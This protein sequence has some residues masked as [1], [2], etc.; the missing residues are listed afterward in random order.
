MTLELYKE[1]RTYIKELIQGSEFENKIYCVGGCCR[2]EILDND[3]KDIDLVIELPDGGINFANWLYNNHYTKGHV[4]LYPRFGTA[5]FKFRKYPDIEIE[6][7]HTRCEKYAN[8]ISRNPET[9]YG[10]ILEDC[11]RR[12]LTINALYYNIS[13][14][15]FEDFCHL[16][17]HDIKNHIIRTPSDPNITYIDD[18]LRILRCVRFSCRY[19]WNIDPETYQALKDNIDRLSIL[20]QERIT[21]E[22]CKIL[23]SPNYIYGLNILEDIGALKYILTPY[24]IQFHAKNNL[25]KHNFYKYQPNLLISSLLDNLYVKMV[26][27]LYP[28]PQY[29]DQIMRIRKF[30]LA[31]NK[32]IFTLINLCQKYIEIFDNEVNDKNI[33]KCQYECNSETKFN[34]LLKC[35][36]VIKPYLFDKLK[37]IN[38]KIHNHYYYQLPINGTDIIEIFNIPSGPKIKDLLNK[39]IDRS[40]EYPNQTKEDCIEYI[41]S[42]IF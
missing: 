2:D 5:M 39:L 26:I 4:Q 27:L 22:F 1:I 38:N 7:V 32:Y 23:N 12:D 20:T 25:F 9:D 21:D 8:G 11:Y 40:F 24:N 35:L 17:L 10:T 6:C 28:Y 18:P 30:S 33:R 31:D 19:L 29:A 41:K 16:S 3:I 15:K 36:Y 37:I 13:K 34:D 14:E 42:M